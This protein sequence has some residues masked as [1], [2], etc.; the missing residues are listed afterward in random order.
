MPIDFSQLTGEEFE[1][2]CRDLLESLG[3]QILEGP[4]RGPDGKKDIIIQYKIKDVIGREKQYK[5]LVQCKN[6]AKSDVENDLVRHPDATKKIPAGC[7]C[8]I[9]ARVRLRMFGAHDQS[10]GGKHTGYHLSVK[11]S[12]GRRRHHQAY[13]IDK[14]TVYPDHRGYCPAQRR[15]RG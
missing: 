4:A 5:L 12:T 7:V 10:T 6:N 15:G 13:R 1:F 2:F 14:V 8:R 9:I 11:T 3:V